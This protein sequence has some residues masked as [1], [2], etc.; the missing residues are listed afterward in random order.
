MYCAEL[1]FRKGDISRFRITIFIKLKI[2]NILNLSILKAEKAKDKNMP[3]SENELKNNQQV[4]LFLQ[5]AS[6][7]IF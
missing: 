1:A 7:F 2:L 6:Q 3:F 4:L 5:F